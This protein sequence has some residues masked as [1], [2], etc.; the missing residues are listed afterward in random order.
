MPI[1]LQRQR[2]Q[3]RTTQ[4]S[5]P[6]PRNRANTPKITIQKISSDLVAQAASWA[7]PLLKRAFMKTEPQPTSSPEKPPE[8][9]ST[10]AEP[11]TGPQ[12]SYLQTLCREAGEEFDSKLTKADASRKIDELQGRTGRGRPI[13]EERTRKT[14]LNYPKEK[15]FGSGS[16]FET[17]QVID[18]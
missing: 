2:P 14:W 3:L 12:A 17:T 11:M 16:V 8:E 4:N 9:W 7:A 5:I 1:P 18:G 13:T 10:G 15:E 6:T